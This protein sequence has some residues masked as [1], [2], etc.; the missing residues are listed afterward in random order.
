[1]AAVACLAL[2]C[3]AFSPE[4]GNDH[5]NHEEAIRVLMPI[6]AQRVLMALSSS[7]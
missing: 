7:A 1:M 2:P 6:G 3:V 4:I 5:G